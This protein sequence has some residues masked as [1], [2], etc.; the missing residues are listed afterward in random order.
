MMS[1]FGLK[2]LLISLP[3]FTFFV[4]SLIMASVFY[5]IP[6]DHKI[7]CNKANVTLC[8]C[9]DNCYPII[10]H[11]SLPIYR[12]TIEYTISDIVRRSMFIVKKCPS[13]QID[14]YYRLDSDRDSP[15]VYRS[16]DGLLSLPIGVIFTL[17]IISFSLLLM[18]IY[19]I[20]ICINNN[21]HILCQN[22]AV[23]LPNTI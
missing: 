21:E 4:T 8:V 23:D 9:I 7:I 6:E 17:S 11:R 15:D 13:G 3:C 16:K 14:I 20:I 12:L 1:W 5:Y 18:M 19:N 2:G 22:E 10:Y